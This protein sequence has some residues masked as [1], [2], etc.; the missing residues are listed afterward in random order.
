MYRARQEKVGPTFEWIDACHLSPQGARYIWPLRIGSGRDLPPPWE[1]LLPLCFA[2]STFTT[3][4]EGC[5][6]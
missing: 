4:R 3:S 1:S 5:F 2:C 6:G